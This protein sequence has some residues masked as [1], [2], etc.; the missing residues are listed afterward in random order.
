MWSQWRYWKMRVLRLYTAPEGLME[1][2]LLLQL[3]HGK[4]NWR[5]LTRR[6]WVWKFPIFRLI[7]YWMRRRSWTWRFVRGCMM[8]FRRSI[9]MRRLPEELQKVWTPTGSA[10]Q[11]TREWG[12]NII[13]D[14]AVVT[15]NFVILCHWRIILIKGLWED[16]S[17]IILTVRYLSVICWR[18]FVSRIL[19]L[20]D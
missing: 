2:L 14:W 7:I 15:N 20:W 9:Y 4:V 16:L 17:G 6:D 3:S 5:F 1:W 13:W 18:T 10:N 12:N 8:M 11:S 19:F